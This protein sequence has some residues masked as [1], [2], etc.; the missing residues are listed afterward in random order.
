MCDVCVLRF[1]HHCPWVGNCV[2]WRNA[3]FFLLLNCWGFWTSL[4]F[5]ATLTGPSVWEIFARIAARQAN[6]SVGQA[7]AIV[8]AAIFMLITAGLCLFNTYLAAWN[9]T[10]VEDLQILGENPYMLSSVEE[11]LRQLLGPL[12]LRVLVPIAPPVHPGS[13]TE[14]P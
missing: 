5:L 7:A 4:V 10:Q 6:A 1:D 9:I 14:F 11:N 3:K 12:D 8:A 13:G 2:G